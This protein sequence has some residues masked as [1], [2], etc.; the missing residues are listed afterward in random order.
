MTSLTRSKISHSSLKLI[1]D[2]VGPAMLDPFS[3]FDPPQVRRKVDVNATDAKNGTA[4]LRASQHC[5]LGALEVLLNNTAA[6]DQLVPPPPGTRKCLWQ[7][8]DFWEMKVP[9]SFGEDCL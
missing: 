4:L 6:V 2:I 5:Q 3:M 8:D 7:N 1:V 9:M